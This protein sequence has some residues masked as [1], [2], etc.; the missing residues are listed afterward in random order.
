M[1]RVIEVGGVNDDLLDRLAAGATPV[2]RV[3]QR[4]FLALVGIACL[5][6]ALTILL[7]IG[8]RADLGAVLMA[9]VFLWK[10]GAMMLVAAVA[11]PMLVAVGRPGAP[12]ARIGRVV[13]ATLATLGLP[14]VYAVTTQPVAESMRGL[15]ATRGLACLGW[16]IIACVP[17]WLA[18]L[19]WLRTAAPTNHARASWA[20]GLVSAAVGASFFV[21]HCPYDDV[22]Y[23]A[24]WYGAAIAGIAVVT[25]LVMP[26]LIHW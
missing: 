12:P 20:A 26:R 7:F 22:V 3:D 9:P 14:L 21:L 15:E 13:L 16:T 6:S 11:L 23:V 5:L 17:V 4:Q 2:R 24:V 19:V 18:S 8:P 1:R 10:L 25:R